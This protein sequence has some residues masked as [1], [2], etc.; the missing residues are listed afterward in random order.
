MDTMDVPGYDYL[1]RYCWTEEA[2]CTN[3]KVEKAIINIPKFDD[4]SYTLD[5]SA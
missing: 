4:P 2:E 1:K 3:G 5:V